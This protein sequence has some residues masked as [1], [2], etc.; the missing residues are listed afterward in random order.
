PI[1]KRFVIMFLED[2]KL[3]KIS[4]RRRASLLIGVN[5]AGVNLQGVDL[6]FNDLQNTN[7]KNA[8]L[9]GADLRKTKLNNANLK[10][11]CYNNYTLFDKNFDPV[12]AGMKEVAQ[13]QM[14]S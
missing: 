6:R 11:S 5:L 7:L 13:S 4:A 9:R 14:C 1:R 8:D 2:T 12:A 10:N 3:L